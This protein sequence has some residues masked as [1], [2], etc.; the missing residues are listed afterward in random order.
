[1]PHGYRRNAVTRNVLRNSSN[2]NCCCDDTFEC[3]NDCVSYSYTGDAFLAASECLNPPVR[4]M[5]EADLYAVLAQAG[6]ASAGVPPVG[7]LVNT[8]LIPPLTANPQAR[9]CENNLMNANIFHGSIPSHLGSGGHGHGHGRSSGG[10]GCG[11]K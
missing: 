8:S 5:S 4:A 10:S 1:M 2:K 3:T 11:C 9:E 6:I 7:A